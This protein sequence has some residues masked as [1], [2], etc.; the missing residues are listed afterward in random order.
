MVITAWIHGETEP[1]A[2][3]VMWVEQALE[4]PPGQMCSLL[5]FLPLGVLRPMTLLEA[6]QTSHEIDDDLKPML[7][8]AATAIIKKSHPSRAALHSV[9]LPGRG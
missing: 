6:I 1:P 4:V 8:A 9:R 2:S 3:C 7:L 5:G